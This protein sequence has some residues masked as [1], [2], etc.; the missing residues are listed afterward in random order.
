MTPNGIGDSA[1]RLGTV[2]GWKVEQSLGPIRKW[3]S[4]MIRITLAALLAL[5]LSACG[6]GGERINAPPTAPTPPPSAPAPPPAPGPSTGPTLSGVVFESTTQG[7]RVLP[8]SRVLYATDHASG[9][10]MSDASGR[11]SV[12]NVPDRSRVRVTA[13]FPSL[14]Q[15]SATTAA[16]DGDTVKDIELVAHGAR[17]VTYGSPTLSGVVY[18]MTREGPQ[19]WPNTMVIYKSFQGPWYD[20]YQYADHQGRYDFGRLS[21]G[22]GQLGAGN[23]NDQ[24][25]FMPVEIG[26]DTVA[27]ID[28][29]WLVNNCPG[30]PF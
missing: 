1:G 10:V 21:L 29:T 22:S 19:P 30:I 2:A 20:V 5:G 4:A 17:G 16:I 26:G 18:H 28:I 8:G 27:D 12:P 13:L 25:M 15:R 7:T 3:S 14:F 23:C 9:Y 11:Y 24:V 6:T